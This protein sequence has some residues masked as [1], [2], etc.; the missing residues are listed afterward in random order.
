MKDFTPTIFS[1]GN[2]EAMERAGNLTLSPEH[3]VLVQRLVHKYERRV[4]Y[5][6]SGEGKRLLKELATLTAHLQAVATSARNLDEN[7]PG[8]LWS[9]ITAEAGVNGSWELN[10]LEAIHSTLRRENAKILKARS[11]KTADY[12]LNDLLMGLENIFKVASGS[13]K[14]GISNTK[15]NRGGRFVRF[16]DAIVGQLGQGRRLTTSV[17]SRWEGLFKARRNAQQRPLHV[18]VGKAP[19]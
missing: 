2:F 11:V 10:R 12:K 1:D 16:A 9:Y 17:G 18:W 3:R 7:R 14:T 4:H 8:H 13:D 6:D 5:E 19:P 15:G